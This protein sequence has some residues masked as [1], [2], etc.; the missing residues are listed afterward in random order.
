MS[1]ALSPDWSPWLGGVPTTPTPTPT[2]TATP[3]PLPPDT[4]TP[5]PPTQAVRP[6]LEC[7]TNHGD[8]TYT[9]YFG[10]KSDNP[11]PVSLPIGAKNKFS[12]TLAERGQPTVFQPGRQVGVF[13]R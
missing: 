13:R 10:Y 2:D 8:G 1:Q 9:A 6:V 7:V 12:P 5:G 11:S 3:T 4:P